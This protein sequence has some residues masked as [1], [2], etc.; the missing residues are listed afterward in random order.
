MKKYLLVFVAAVMF[1]LTACSRAEVKRDE[2]IVTTNNI[3][4]EPAVTEAG[5]IEVVEPDGSDTAPV[6]DTGTA[7]AEDVATAGTEDT[8]TSEQEGNIPAE[9]AFVI[10]DIDYDSATYISFDGIELTSEKSSITYKLCQIKVSGDRAW[11]IICA[12]G[13]D[14]G[15]V[16]Y[17]EWYTDIKSLLEKKVCLE[18]MDNR[19]FYGRYYYDTFGTDWYGRQYFEMDFGTIDSSQY[20]T[21]IGFGDKEYLAADYCTGMGE[22]MIEI[23]LMNYSDSYS[24]DSFYMDD[25]Y[26]HV[27]FRDDL[28]RGQYYHY[29]SQGEG[30]AQIDNMYD[31]IMKNILED[32]SGFKAVSVSEGFRKDGELKL[33]TIDNS[34]NAYFDFYFDITDMN[35]EFGLLLYN[36]ETDTYSPDL[37]TA[38]GEAYDEE[39]Y[40]PYSVESAD[41]LEILL[42]LY[43][44]LMPQID[45]STARKP[46]AE[47]IYT[48]FI[49]EDPERL[50]LAADKYPLCSKTHGAWL[51]LADKKADLVFL[52]MPTEEEKEYLRERDISVDIKVYGCDGL[53]FI[54]SAD[55][56][57]K[58]LTVDQ[59]RDIY[60][61][62]ITNWSELGGPDHAIVP[63][64][65]N[66]QSGSQRMFEEFLWPDGNVPDFSSMKTIDDVTETFVIYDEMGAIVEGVISD[67]YAIGYNMVTYVKNEFSWSEVEMI[68]VNGVEPVTENFSNGSYPFTTKAYVA[69]RFDEPE[70]SPARLLYNWIGECVYFSSIAY[71]RSSLS[72]VN[73]ETQTLVP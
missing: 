62:K 9:S 73:G 13:P 50:K 66:E 68:K 29:D 21:Y 22:N 27:I 23:N 19:Y 20:F 24:I 31:I 5:E 25:T 67:P 48:F 34:G 44:E 71:N 30:S 39:K 18:T 61:G 14:G 69:I 56:P 51:N 63:C 17:S 55:A 60:E 64:Y 57:V 4:D 2:V 3:T 1:I 53:A 45:S 41:D 37:N 52:V 35:P 70:N 49:G 8:E 46:I 32:I 40:M 38:Y 11:A 43:P 16:K 59:I 42:T 15:P 72:L 33:L 54:V 26:A 47:D 36:P 58:D 12:E 10:S 65:R 7:T 28:K 6:E